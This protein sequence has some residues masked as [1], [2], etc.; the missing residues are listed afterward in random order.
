M[1]N[2]QL[3]MRIAKETDRKEIQ[4]VLGGGGVCLS[5]KVHF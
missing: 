4:A 2:G 1:N 5:T 3:G